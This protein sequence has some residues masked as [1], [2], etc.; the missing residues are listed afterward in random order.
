MKAM[1]IVTKTALAAV[2]L[3]ATVASAS[4]QQGPTRQIQVLAAPGAVQAQPAADVAA[5]KPEVAQVNPAPA[6]EAVAPKVEA[7]PAPVDPNVV[8][9]PKVEPKFVAPIIE[10]PAR[11]AY[12]YNGYGYRAPHC[13]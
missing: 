7:A 10:K 6:P 1:N 3:A 12:G 2:L 5:A 13:H 9:A 11:K 8:V 4:A